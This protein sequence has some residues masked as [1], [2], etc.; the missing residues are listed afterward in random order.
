MHIILYPGGASPCTQGLQKSTKVMSGTSK[1]DRQKGLLRVLGELQK[2][3]N[4]QGLLRAL[5]DYI[6]VS[7]KVILYP[8]GK[9]NK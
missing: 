8:G 9:N 1:V 4:A 7:T 5:R 6:S 3:T 2:M